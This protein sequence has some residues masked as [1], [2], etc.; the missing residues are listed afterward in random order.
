LKRRDFLTRSAA[1]VAGVLSAPWIGRA[2][3]GQTATDQVVLGKT[4][5]KA[6]RIAMGTGFNGS[7]RSS[8][9]VRLGKEAFIRLMHHGFDNGINF[10]DMADLYGS[11]NFMST[12][13]KDIGRERMVLLSKIWWAEGGGMEST[14]RAIPSVDRF[15]KELG[16]EMIDVCLIHCV[17]N[18][19]WPNEL[20]RMRDELDELKQKGVI[21]ATGVSCHDFGALEVAASDPWVDLIF[22]R[23]N[24]R[25]KV[26]D[27]SDPNAVAAVLKKARANG[28]A[29][30]GMKIY[31]AGQ[32]VEP[33]QREESLRFVWGNQLVDAMTIGF[34]KP[35]YVDETISQLN[36]VFRS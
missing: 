12:V 34:E 30:V 32:L 29:V 5:I 22:A 28:K 1:G 10:F 35:V 31:G 3:A 13:I 4:G 9:Q 11:H 26:M 15:R 20:K 18:S 24:N 19:N 2:F 7:G 23:I 27:H 16:T 17:T 21:K 33:S 6:S 36:S 25:A 14:D 8:A